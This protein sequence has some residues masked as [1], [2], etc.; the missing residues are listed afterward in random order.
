MISQFDVIISRRTYCLSFNNYTGIP[1]ITKRILRCN[2]TEMLP[3]LPLTNDENTCTVVPNPMEGCLMV[4]TRDD[5]NRL[6][7]EEPIVLLRPTA[8]LFRC[9]QRLTVNLSLGAISRRLTWRRNI[10]HD[11]DTVEPQIVCHDFCRAI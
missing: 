4:M 5:R 11:D 1:W 7:K 3:N 2:I 10:P 8:H 6:H 9:D